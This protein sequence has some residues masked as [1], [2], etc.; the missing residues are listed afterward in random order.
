MDPDSVSLDRYVGICFDGDDYNDEAAAAVI[1]GKHKTAVSGAHWFQSLRESTIACLGSMK[2]DTILADPP[3]ISTFRLRCPKSHEH[4][5]RDAGSALVACADKGLVVLYGGRY[6]GP[7]AFGRGCYLVYGAATSATNRCRLSTVPPIPQSAYLTGIGA[8]AVVLCRHYPSS[9]SSSYL[10]AELDMDPEHGLPD[11]EL[12]LWCSDSATSQWVKKAV[13]LPPEVC[14]EPGKHNFCADASFSFGTSSMCW[15]DLLHGIVVCSNLVGQQADP[16]FRF[17]P[18]PEGCPTGGTVEEAR[19][20][21][22]HARTSSA[23]LAALAASSSSSPL[24]ASSNGGWQSDQFRLA[25]WTLSPDL[26]E[27]KKGDV[28]HLQDLWASEQYLALK[29]PR[30]TPIFPALSASRDDVVYAIVNDLEKHNIVQGSEVVVK[31]QYVLELDM[32]RNRIISTSCGHPASAMQMM[33][34]QVLATDI[35]AYQNGAKDG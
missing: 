16:Q 8:G 33:T 30:H 25:T 10:L 20:L 26:N 17:I 7:G 18:L 3:G 19:S 27:W 35:T 32:Q 29:L 24:W 6:W 2:L 34:L 14:R 11:A 12:Y 4:A 23:L 31:G 5:G 22:A 21:T 13:R 9:L 15:V 28:F 1:I